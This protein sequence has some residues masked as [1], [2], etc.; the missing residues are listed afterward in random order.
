MIAQSSIQPESQKHTV[1]LRARAPRLRTGPH[2]LS[3]LDHVGDTSLIDRSILEQL[4][5]EVKPK[6]KA[7]K[8]KSNKTPNPPEDP[9][10]LVEKFL[11]EGG[12]AHGPRR[13]FHGGSKW[14]LQVCPFDSAHV[15]TSVV[16]TVGE[17]GAYGF[18]C[19]HDSCSGN[20]WAEFRKFVEGKIGQKFVFG[21]KEEADTER[22]IYTPGDLTSSAVKSEQIL[23][24]IR[25]DGYFESDRRLVVACYARDEEHPDAVE[26]EIGIKRDKNAV[27]VNTAPCEMLLC[28]LDLNAVF[29]SPAGGG[30]RGQSGNTSAS[31]L[32]LNFL[33]TC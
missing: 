17:D 6:D 2:R 1:R 26:K 5:A 32:Y 15:A 19:M 21:G 14:E 27:I 23:A 7:P 12:I 24:A 20:H 30:Q 18:R 9:A 31:F 10:A 13:D 33:P 3:R 16:A 22:I 28:D 11:A 25:P 29:Q 4:A 8:S